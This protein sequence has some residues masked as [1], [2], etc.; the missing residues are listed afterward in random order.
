MLNKIILTITVVFLLSHKEYCWKDKR[1]PFNIALT[2]A[3]EP[4]LLPGVILP[5]YRPHT[6]PE[7]TNREKWLDYLSSNPLG[8]LILL[9][10]D[11]GEVG[12]DFNEFDLYQPPLVLN[13]NRLLA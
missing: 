5:L 12:L 3:G 9:H 13:D 1:N 4:L 2:A 8:K 11:M 6:H 7:L 10:Q